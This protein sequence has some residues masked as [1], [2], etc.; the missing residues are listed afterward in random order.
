[1]AT[2][3]DSL[4]RTNAEY[5]TTYLCAPDTRFNS[6][7]YT[8][9]YITLEESQKFYAAVI[10]RVSRDHYYR[11]KTRPS[12]FLRFIGFY[13]NMLLYIVRE[14]GRTFIF[15]FF[16]RTLSDDNNLINSNQPTEMVI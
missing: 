4:K 12:Y 10:R 8:Q 3:Y 13:V 7:L 6:A 1:M 9:T 16:F 11:L 2:N 14:F 5:L 15:F